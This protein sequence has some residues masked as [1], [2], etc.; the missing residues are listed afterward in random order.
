MI[1]PPKVPNLRAAAIAV[2]LSSAL[3][4]HG[5]MAEWQAHKMI[6]DGRIISHAERSEAGGKSYVTLK[7]NASR[8]Q[9]DKPLQ[10]EIKSKKQPLSVRV[11]DRAGKSIA[12]EKQTGGSFVEREA[13]EVFYQASE[14]T[15][16]KVLPEGQPIHTLVVE[17]PADAPIGSIRISYVAKEKVPFLKTNLTPRIA[18]VPKQTPAPRAAR[19]A[20]T[21][22]GFVLENRFLKAGFSTT[23]GLR[24]E[25]LQNEYAGK[26]M[27]L[28]PAQTR[29]FLIEIAGQR[30]GAE[31]WTV[32]GTKV[33]SPQE[34]VVDLWL[35]SHRLAASLT[36]SID[37]GGLQL[38]LTIE[39]AGEQDQ[40]WKTVFPQLGGLSISPKPTADY[41]LF[42]LRGG[43][44]QTINANLRA[45]YGANV[46][47]WQMLTLYSPELGTSFSM[48]CLDE[49]GIYKGIAM[50]KGASA[51]EAA[52]VTEDITI[53]TMAPTQTWVES[54]PEGEGTA[55]AFEYVE[56]SR[57]P[58]KA[59]T[60][61]EAMLEVYAGDWRP[62]MQTYADWAHRIW[63]WQPL[64]SKLNDI[65]QIQVVNNTIV[66]GGHVPDLVTD[67]KWYDGYADT[68][69]DMS[70]FGSWWEPSRKGP[71]GTSLANAEK[72][73]GPRF[74]RRYKL[75]HQHN[76]GTKEL[77]WV[78]GGRGD[79][80][81]PVSTG[82]WPAM[83]GAIAAAHKAG[84]L[85]ALYTSPMLISDHSKIG[86]AHGKE[87]A[88]VNP[89]WPP[90]PADVLPT[91]PRDGYVIRH[92]VWRVCIGLEAYQDFVARQMADLIKNTGAD[93]I[94]LDEV[95]HTGLACFNPEHNHLF[96]EPGHHTWM[97]S[98]RSMTAK[99]R[100]A[101][102]EVKPD[103]LVMAEYP[104]SDLLSS[105]LDGALTYEAKTWSH[106]GLR[107][108]P[109]N[110]FRFYF[111]EVRL[112]ELRPETSQEFPYGVKLAFWNGV[113]IFAS[114]LVVPH[115]RILKENGD[116]F[117]SRDVEPLVPTLSERVYANRF[118]KGEKEIVLLFNDR[119]SEVNGEVLRASDSGEHH[120]FDLLNGK[121]L[122]VEK[123]SVSLRVASK[124]V[125]AVARLPR[126]MELTESGLRLRREVPDAKIALCDAEGKT[127]E[128]CA[129]DQAAELLAK[130]RAT[131]DT[132][133]KLFSGGTLMDA[134]SH[135]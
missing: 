17:A 129:P 49:E 26:D 78:G 123:G 81:E 14:G 106:R 107:V 57:A 113:G 27:L 53:E 8:F 84:K 130:H 134:A 131:P 120:Y 28:D 42:P 19:M 97:R 128:Q 44:V 64:D 125:A 75:E 51:S 38:G 48:R 9:G 90:L 103:A 115:Y 5:Q 68:D 43:V 22:G 82:G 88:V 11:I 117:R 71:F 92:M 46:A 66:G 127:L 60:Y 34:V 45:T 59:I 89:H 32:K 29:L 6:D 63:K 85:V 30:I 13:G 52:T 50:R 91:A 4:S 109:V 99:V 12:T 65:W 73:I 76:A 114:P 61:P 124:D 135:R 121:E 96:G 36:A 105:E 1:V 80:S 112:Y 7:F 116:A 56:S 25:S 86:E 79:Y 41:Y 40:T 110:I 132:Y 47:W 87:Y 35:E 101:M 95:G 70:E 16:L 118:S 54:L 20:E 55:F 58:G 67:G 74:Y 39:N 72:E 111:P 133:L 3:L 94:R 62:A 108:V 69:Y 18:A 119:E 33:N 83:R 100:T 21:K 122:V 23:N 126:V 102:T 10:L 104:G 24:L 93:V 2:F 37:E 15:T 31:Q 77:T 98:M